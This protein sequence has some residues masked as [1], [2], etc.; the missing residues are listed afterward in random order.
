LSRF[1]LAATA[2][3]PAIL[4]TAGIAHA[5]APSVTA[6]HS[7]VK[8]KPSD[9]PPA[10]T[11]AR[12]AA[13]ANELE[14]FQAVISGGDSGVRGVS[15]KISP[16]RGP[17]TISPESVVLYRQAY[18]DVRTPSD[19]NGMRG[20]IPDAL[21][22]NV[23]PYKGEKRNAFPFD[24]PAGETRVIWVDVHVPMGSAPGKYSGK[25]ELEG[26]GGFSAS[27]PIELEV[28]PFELPSNPS[29]AT[30][31]GLSWNGTCAGHFGDAW[32]NGDEETFDELR[33]LYGMAGL[34]NRISFSKVAG[35]PVPASGGQVDFSRYDR[36]Y[37]PLL[38]GNAPTRIPGAALSTIEVWQ[39]N[40]QAEDYAAWAQHFKD[41]GWYDKLFDYTCDEPPLT[42]EW[43]DIKPRQ[44]RVKGGDPTMKSLITTTVAHLKNH[45]LYESTDIIVPVVNFVE[46]KVGDYAGDNSA[47][48]HQAKADG[49]TV[50]I[51]SSCMSH[52]CGNT[53]SGE[54]GGDPDLH[55]WPS[56]VIDHTSLQ[57]RAMPWV[58]YNF[59]FTGEL[60]WDSAYS[61]VT[62]RD[63]WTD[64]Y[65]FTGNGDG[66]LFY[67][68]RPDKIGGSTHIPV[69]SLRLKV[70]R[71]GIE[72]YEYLT[73]LDAFDPDAARDASKR[74]FPHA[75]SAGDISPEELLET[76]REVAKQIASH[77][78]KTGGEVPPSDLRPDNGGAFGSKGGG[79]SGGGGG[80]GGGCSA[81]PAALS[82]GAL[83]ALAPLARL[84]RKRS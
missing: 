58:A 38:D 1:S 4:L 54:Y 41:M 46:G 82:A 31:F 21:I 76:R 25:L 28:F 45:G 73:I 75:W 10:E 23:D 61:F 69:E 53:V 78:K 27:L 80:G 17:S 64:Q 59:G 84:R 55:G 62:K 14:S 2:V 34:D 5:A 77:T 15:A 57:H 13:A 33:Q 9:P 19:D 49:K 68:G 36:T 47:D 67:P 30:A 71:D 12:I 83:L 74:L 35:A 16:L 50:W 20:M 70:I 7:L 32:C 24:V 48:Y 26:D 60:Y 37:G 43:S 11:T 6:T 63:P 81:S 72:D 79:S 66:T 18:I 56:L 44:D 65:D 29:Y 22:P 42:C 8:L 52:G 40:P 3:L 51:Y 39:R